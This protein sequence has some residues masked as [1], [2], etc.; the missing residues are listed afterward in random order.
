MKLLAL[1]TRK[2][3]ITIHKP[4]RMKPNLKHIVAALCMNKNVF[5]NESPKLIAYSTNFN[6]LS[7]E[8]TFVEEGA[9]ITVSTFI[10]T[11]SIT[12]KGAPSDMVVIEGPAKRFPKTFFG[13]RKHFTR[14]NAR[15][16]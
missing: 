10:G 4:F 15:T 13:Q 12:T 1:K 2:K 11:K 8:K 16:S 5:F 7:E 14:I 6:Y 9:A 3:L